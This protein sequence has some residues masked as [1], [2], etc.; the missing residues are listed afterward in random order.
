MK[1]AAWA[2]Y[3]YIVIQLIND[4]R[5]AKSK[6]QGSEPRG[7][8]YYKVNGCHIWGIFTRYSYCTESRAYACYWIPRFVYSWSDLCC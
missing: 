1:Y 7:A 8:Y 3:C 2:V 5:Q 6:K 4:G